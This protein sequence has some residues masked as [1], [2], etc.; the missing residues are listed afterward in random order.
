M[1]LFDT[2]YQA[3][4]INSTVARTE[5]AFKAGMLFCV[6]IYLSVF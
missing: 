3:A 2:D 5:A 1:K 4:G 6:F